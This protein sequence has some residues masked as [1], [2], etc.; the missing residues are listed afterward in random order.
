MTQKITPPPGSP[1]TTPQPGNDARNLDSLEAQLAAC[2]ERVS[3]LLKYLAHMSPS[4][5]TVH[6]RHE[7]DVIQ[8]Y[9]SG[10]MLPLIRALRESRDA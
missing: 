10:A 1:I 7:V 2:R 8:G 6:I 5:E 9:L 3:E 4:T